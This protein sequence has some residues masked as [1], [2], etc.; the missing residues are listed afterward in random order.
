MESRYSS[1]QNIISDEVKSGGVMQIV[2]LAWN[3][4]QNQIVFNTSSKN[5]QFCYSILTSQ[6]CHVSIW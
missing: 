6:N 4:N 3:Q 1:V 5:D 2:K